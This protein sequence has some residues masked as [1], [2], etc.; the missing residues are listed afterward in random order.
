MLNNTMLNE[1]LKLLPREIVKKIVDDYKGDRYSKTFKSW[2]DLVAM[3][4]GQLA[5]VASLRELAI[6]IN[7]HSE[8]HYHLHTR[9]VKRSSVFQMPTI[10]AIL[11]FSVILQQRSFLKLNTQKKV[12]DKVVTVLDSSLIKPKEAG[13]MNGQ[14]I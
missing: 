7:S 12:I 14:M 1:I 4:T 3:I 2:D 9:E 13:G 8:S 6:T 10:T 11:L 5:G